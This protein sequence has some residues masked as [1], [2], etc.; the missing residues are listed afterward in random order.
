MTPTLME[1]KSIPT[2][3]LLQ[4]RVSAKT[5]LAD[6]IAGFE[7]VPLSGGE[8]PAFEAGAHIDVHVPGDMV[9]QYS[10]YDPAGLQSSYRIGVL[11]DPQS[12]GGSV[13]LVDSVQAGDVLTISAPRNHFAL[14]DGQ[15]DQS[16]LFAGGIGI[17]PILCMAQQL[18]RAGRAFALHYCGRSLSRMAL[19]DR[20]QPSHF[21][22]A[23]QV[24]VH[25]DDGTAEQ[26]LDA[27]SAI[28]T[29]S[30]DKHLYVCGPNGFMNH[31]LQTARELGWDEG[32]LH[33]EYFGA[34]P[35]ETAGD[36]PFEIE[37]HRSGE[38]IVVAADQSAA[39]ALLDAGF[40]LPLSCEQGVCGTCMTKVL[41]GQPDHRDLY[42][43]D[44]ERAGNDCFMPCC[45]RAKTSRLVLD[46]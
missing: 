13:K 12:R 38:V 29:P 44:G 23:P 33:R 8:L 2:Q 24:H 40:S 41:A 25:V 19:I 31:I 17:T 5:W 22:E 35:I 37:I 10:L 32:H 15:Q 7:L 46:L 42:L 6:D 3:A 45:S 16:I 1:N 28:G 21:G 20:L 36:A 11:R 26:Q 27:R 34:D 14:H 18:G 30:F 39:H 4:V 9:R 43:T